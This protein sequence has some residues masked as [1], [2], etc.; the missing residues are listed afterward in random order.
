MSL[1]ID[2]VIFHATCPDGYSSAWLLNA[3]TSNEPTFHEGRY[4]EAPPDG[5][6]GVVVIADF[7]YDPATLA[8]MASR[9]DRLV[10]LDHHETA[11]EAIEAYDGEFPPSCEFILDVNRSGCGITA[12]WL[13]VFANRTDGTETHKGW[14]SWRSTFIDYMEDRDLWR[15]SLPQCRAIIAVANATAMHKPGPGMF[16]EW[17]AMAERVNTDFDR[18]AELGQAVVDREDVLIAQAMADTT[19]VTICG[20][21]NIPVVSTPY[22]LGSDSAAALC[23]A[24]PDAPFAAYYIDHDVDRQFGLRSR[25]GSDFS[26]A[27]LAKLHYGGGGHPT[28]AGFR[29]PWGHELAP[30][31]RF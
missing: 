15:F 20:Y 3:A 7:S 14:G 24:Y 17:A 27:K 13:D 26:L 22:G 12:D 30:G 11:V 6:S 8:D 10:V 4:G 31:S 25:P 2:H 9:C 28:A 16:N 18:I 29:V 5:L 23:D 21:P 19:F 1:T